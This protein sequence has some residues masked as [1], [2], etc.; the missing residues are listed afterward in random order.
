MQRGRRDAPR[1]CAS[2]SSLRTLGSI[3]TRG[4]TM[5]GASSRVSRT[6]SCRALRQRFLQVCFW[7]HVS[8][9]L[10]SRQD[11]LRAPYAGL[12][13]WRVSRSAQQEIQ[14]IGCVAQ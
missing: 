10:V 2:G 1:I 7:E 14:C 8:L 5:A 4:R 13:L 11:M 9:F 6:A 12:C 3:T